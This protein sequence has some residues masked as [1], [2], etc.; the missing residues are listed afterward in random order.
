MI[1][2]ENLTEAQRSCIPDV[3]FEL[4]PIKNLV[5][6]QKYQRDLKEAHITSTALDFNIYQIKLFNSKYFKFLTYK[7]NN[8]IFLKEISISMSEAPVYFSE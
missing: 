6:N 4:I 7:E 8:S 2:F 5:S 3:R 1:D